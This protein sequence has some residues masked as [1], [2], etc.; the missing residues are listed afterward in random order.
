MRKILQNLVL[1]SAF[2]FL[3]APPVSAENSDVLC[4]PPTSL[5]LTSLTQTSADLTWVVSTQGTNSGVYVLKV[6]SVALTN[7][8]SQS[9][10]KF[11]GN[12]TGT[13]QPITGLSPNT[14]YYVYIQTNCTSSSEGSST[15]FSTTFRTPC[16]SVAAPVVEIFDNSSSLPSCW[17]TA[18]NSSTPPTTNSTTFAG[19]SGR[20]VKLTATTTTD[21]Y[22][23]SPAIQRV[24]FM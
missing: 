14:L 10:D 15:W 16:N 19:A 5:L 8:N 9:G 20:S 7:L 11:N 2:L 12:V 3:Y 21:T 23:I 22:F 4:A 1:F 24:Y 6:S 13:F 17:L 18:G